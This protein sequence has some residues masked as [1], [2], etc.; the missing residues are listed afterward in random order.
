MGVR[1]GRERARN[2]RARS[3][4][5]GERFG[6]RVALQHREGGECRERTFAEVGEL[7]DD[8]ALG[9]VAHGLEPGDRACILANTRPEWTFASLAISRA[10]GVVVPIY[11]NDSP[12]KCEWV[13]GNSEAR[14]IV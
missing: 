13:A 2:S 8:V 5:R 12:E 14:M 11:P 7:V 3:G 1:A 9:L 6:D 4:D 10:G